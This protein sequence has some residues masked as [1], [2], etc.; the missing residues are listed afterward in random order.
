MWS[1]HLIKK[2]QGGVSGAAFFP[3]EE[4]YPLP[5]L[6]SRGHTQPFAYGPHAS[7]KPTITGHVLLHAA[8]GKDFPL[9]R[10]D[11]A[12]LDNPE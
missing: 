3:G 2:D 9:L 6:A 12:H 4:T 10:F 5:V 7:S 11:W 1:G 8:A